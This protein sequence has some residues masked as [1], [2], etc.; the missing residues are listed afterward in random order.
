MSD[1]FLSLRINQTTVV[2]E[3]IT[4]FSANNIRALAVFTVPS[5]KVNV[6]SRIPFWHI[7]SYEQEDNRIMIMA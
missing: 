6:E 5:L 4:G 7:C 2:C 1:Q 3:V